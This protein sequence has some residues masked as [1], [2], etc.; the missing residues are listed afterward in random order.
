MDFGHEEQFRERDELFA[1]RE[2]LMAAVMEA[3]MRLVVVREEKIADRPVRDVLRERLDAL[4]W[5]E[6]RFLA[7]H[8][9]GHEMP[10]IMF[11]KRA[12][13]GET[14]TAPDEGQP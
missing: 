12:V 1:D 10:A 13:E 14:E 5:P 3:M 9:T 7:A 6:F 2:K 4:P 11:W 8:L